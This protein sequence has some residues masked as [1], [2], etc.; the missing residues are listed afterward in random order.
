MP[1]IE[2]LTQL[3]EETLRACYR[4]A[5]REALEDQDKGLDPQHEQKRADLKGE[6]DRRDWEANMPE[7]ETSQGI[8]GLVHR[9]LMYEK[10]KAERAAKTSPN[11]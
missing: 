2:D 11:L 10:T 9:Q 6:L 5:Y 4:N 1:D 8:E 3:D 7:A